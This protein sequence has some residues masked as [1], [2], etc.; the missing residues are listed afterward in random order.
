MGLRESACTE[1]R[2]CHLVT[3]NQVEDLGAAL[4]GNGF[5]PWE[6][7]L[8]DYSY[9]GVGHWGFPRTADALPSEAERVLLGKP[10]PLSARARPVRAFS[11]RRDLRLRGLD[12]S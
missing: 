2:T 5:W 10:C 1:K 9:E 7:Y 3:Q 8:L 4:K 12:L 6:S 11:A